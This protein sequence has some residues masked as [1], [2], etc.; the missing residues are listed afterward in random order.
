MTRREFIVGTSAVGCVG[1]SQA[2]AAAV[3]VREAGTFDVVVAGGGP[4]GIGAAIGAARAGAK[5]MLLELHGALGGVWTSGQLAC[6][7]GFDKSALD[8]EIT[9][10]LRA[11][12]A[13]TPRRPKNPE[14]FAANYLSEPEYLKVVLDD[15]LTEAGVSFRFHTMVVAAEREGDRIAAVVTESKSGRERWR[16]KTFVDAT[17]DGDLGA[18]AG[19]GFEIGDGKGGPDQPA[20]LLATVIVPESEGL[21]RFVANDILNYEDDGQCLRNPKEALLAELHRVGV[22]PSYHAPTLA[23]LRPGLFSLM[24]THAYGVR[25]DDA[26]AITAATV[27]ARKETL[28][29]VEALAKKGG[30]VWREMRIVHLADQ[31]AHRGGRRIRGRYRLTVGDVAAGRTFG[32]AVATSSF[33]IDIHATNFEANRVAPSGNPEA[34]RFHP[35]QIPLRACR[36]K[37]VDNLYMAGRCISGDFVS[38]ASYRVTGTAVAVGTA[39][40]NAAAKDAEVAERRC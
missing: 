20:S 30:P 31:L 10:R 36:A 13:G 35:F 1:S 15:L 34:L 9:A 7:I 8:R 29:M 4:A 21:R 24:A 38:Q 3:P 39:V 32:D 37:D 14:T 26:A 5:V 11:L 23:R 6:M 19:C 27:R 40:G 16:A 18:A 25:V 2:A 12:G 17:G 22:D 28:T 33:G